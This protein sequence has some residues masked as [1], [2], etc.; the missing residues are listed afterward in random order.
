MWCTNLGVYPQLDSATKKGTSVVA[1]ARKLWSKVQRR[2]VS[3]R[4]IN[5]TF[6]GCGRR[7]R[8]TS[9]P[10]RTG[11][12]SPRFLSAARKTHARGPR[13]YSDGL[14]GNIGGVYKGVRS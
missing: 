9:S 1:R 6:R 13:E 4:P 8:R 14:L 11:I 5:R 7:P 3:G 10:M 2:V 12:D